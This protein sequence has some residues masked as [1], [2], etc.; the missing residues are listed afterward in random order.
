ME[1]QQ[2]LKPGQKVH[3]TF[4]KGTDFYLDGSLVGHVTKG[5]EWVY[6]NS[7]NGCGKCFVQPGGYGELYI[8]AKRAFYDGKKVIISG[9][10]C[11]VEDLRGSRRTKDL[12]KLLEQADF[13]LSPVYTA[14]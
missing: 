3:I 2:R 5:N 14:H 13:E 11:F 10:A 4:S 9:E 7:N 12:I 8:Y 1:Q 6:T